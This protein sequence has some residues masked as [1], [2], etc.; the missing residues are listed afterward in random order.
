MGY[1]E[2]DEG[3]YGSCSAHHEPRC[4]RLSMLACTSPAQLRQK[5]TAQ[6]AV[7][8]QQMVDTSSSS[9]PGAGTPVRQALI[10]C[11]VVAT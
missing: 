7:E 9:P 3:Q 2:M 10:F 6:P 11:L 8:V 1:D 5:S 4:G